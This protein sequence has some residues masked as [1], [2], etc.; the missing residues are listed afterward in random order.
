[1]KKYFSIVLLGTVV[2]FCGCQKEQN[3]NQKKGTPEEKIETAITIDSLAVVDAW[4][5][6]AAKGSNSALFF[7]II[8][9]ADFPDTIYSVKSDLAAV[10]EVH[11]SYQN[12]DGT[13]GMRQVNFVEIVSKSRFFFKP[14]SFHIMLI[15]L[16]HDLKQDETYEA[17]LFFKRKGEVKIKAIVKDRMPSQMKEGMKGH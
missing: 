9:G 1:M 12:P 7:E 13:M 3:E 14:K 17:S 11:E 10:V 16:N 8:N 2:F 6:P 4:I 15:I 5:R